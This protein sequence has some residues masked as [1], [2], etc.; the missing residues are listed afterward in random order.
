M[1]PTIPGAASHDPSV[2]VREL[3]RLLDPPQAGR[4]FWY[5]ILA[6]QCY[7]RQRLSKDIV[8]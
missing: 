2:A 3:Q 1:F 5:P 8:R 4:H 7:I 6:V